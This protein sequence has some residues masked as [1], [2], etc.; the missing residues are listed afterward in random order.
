[1]RRQ[2]SAVCH[3]LGKGATVYRSGLDDMIDITLWCN[4]YQ[5]PP[6]IDRAGTHTR[7]EGS[8]I[9]SSRPSNNNLEHGISFDRAAGRWPRQD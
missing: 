3:W 7:H 9:D 1:M 2:Q 8:A 6:S 5:V 4:C